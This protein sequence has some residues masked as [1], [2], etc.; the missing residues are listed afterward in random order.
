MI[1]NHVKVIYLNRDRDNQEYAFNAENHDRIKEGKYNTLTVD[2]SSTVMRQDKARLLAEFILM[3]LEEERFHAGDYPLF[4]SQVYLPEKF[5]TLE[6][7]AYTKGKQVHTCVS[8]VQL[9]LH[10]GGAEKLTEEINRLLHESLEKKFEPVKPH[11]SMR[12]WHQGRIK[13]E[14]N[15]LPGDKLN[16]SHSFSVNF[17]DWSNKDET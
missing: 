13:S 3:F 5:L 9:E 15:M 11:V 7:L 10:W 8:S 12:L 4:N 17:R 14:R 1:P 16:L 6:G 2:L